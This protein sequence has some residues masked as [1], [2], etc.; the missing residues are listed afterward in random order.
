MNGVAQALVA[1]IV[2]GAVFASI[3]AALVVPLIAWIAVRSLTPAI[4]KMNGDWR[5]QAALAA[6]AASIPGALFL[7]LVTYGLAT[8]ASSV[9][10]QTSPG[11][12]LF[13]TLAALML[14]AIGRAIVHAL[15]RSR[16]AAHAVARS[17]PASPRLAR[18]A[19][20]A[21]VSAYQLPDDA[22]SIVMLYGGRRA[23][24]YVSTKALRELSDDDLLAALHHER[25]HQ[26]RGDHRIA[27]VLYFLTDLLPLPVGDLV[28]AYRWSREFCADGHA[29]QHVS[30]SDLAS[31]LLQMVAPQSGPAHAAAFAEAAVLHD[32]LRALLLHEVP[33]AS[34]LRRAVMTA[35]LLAIVAVG[36]AV[37]LVA[38]L[39]VHC[40]NMGLS[41]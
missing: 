3:C 9:C 2:S 40:S 15:H 5:G 31:A 11:R 16:D 28:R 10:L 23:A 32:R 14:A 20:Q 24:V 30:S 38:P 39:F 27:L 4:Q 25:A 18:I 12:A 33:K 21:A 37:P 29:L 7:F 8:S 13:G 19:A 22:Q 17:L 41:S 26:M 35:A 1:C 6:F 36:A 34:Q